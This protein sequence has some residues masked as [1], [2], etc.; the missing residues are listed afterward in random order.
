MDQFWYRGR[1]KRGDVLIRK[2]D[3][4]YRTTMGKKYTIMDV[5]TEGRVTYIS[6]Q[7]EPRTIIPLSWAWELCPTSIVVGGE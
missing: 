7:G 4:G 1:F 3:V 2:V 5:D 6:D